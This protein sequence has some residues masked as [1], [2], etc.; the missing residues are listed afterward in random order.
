MRTCTCPRTP[1][2]RSFTTDKLKGK[3]KGGGCLWGTFFLLLFFSFCFFFFFFSFRKPFTLHCAA[4]RTAGKIALRARRGGGEGGRVFSPLRGERYDGNYVEKWTMRERGDSLHW[5]MQRVFCVHVRE[6]DEGEGEGDQGGLFYEDVA[7]ERGTMEE[8]VMEILGREKKLL[9]SLLSRLFGN[10]F[11]TDERFFSIFFFLW[12]DGI[13]TW[14]LLLSSSL[15]FNWI[16]LFVEISLWSIGKIFSKFYTGL[17]YDE[18]TF[19]LGIILSRLVL[20][21]IEILL[22]FFY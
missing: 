22:A 19:V 3:E 9:R 8:F 16:N 4:S 7:T 1:R 5:R 15:R 10:K 17:E 21:K 11:L 18:N 2:P 13:L 6:V 20:W 12:M 14:R